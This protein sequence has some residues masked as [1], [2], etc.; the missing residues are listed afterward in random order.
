MVE[1]AEVEVRRL[2]V[3]DQQLAQTAMLLLVPEDERDG[4]VPSL[5]HLRQLL[6]SSSNCLILALLNGKPIGFT[7]AYT[8]P[9]YER[10]GKMAYLFDIGV[11]PEHHRKGIASRMI[12]L[13][14]ECMHRQG[15]SSVWVG[16][17]VNNTPAISLY[18][19][20]GAKRVPFVINELWYKDL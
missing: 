7:I 19:S 20:T 9:Q 6:D 1:N 12:G 10:D 16:A 11:V 14:K 17:D 18:E 8:M 3:G 15:V 2:G 13:L 4:Q 5:E